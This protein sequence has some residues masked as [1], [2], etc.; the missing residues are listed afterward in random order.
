LDIQIITFAGLTI[1][2]PVTSLTDIVLA[3]ISFTFFARIK[4]RL[5]E[6]FFNNSW[7]MFFLFIGIST[8]IGAFAHALNGTD[9]IRWSAALF[10]AMTVFSSFAVFFALKATIRFT[11]LPLF[12]RKGLNT[13]NYS[14]LVIFMIYTLTTNN[15]EIFKMH[16][17]AGLLLI[18][19]THA[20]AWRRSHTGSGWIMAGM[21]ISF[22]TVLVHTKQFSISPWFNYKD[23][24]HVIMMVS[25]VMIYNGVYMMSENL[26][27]G[28][29]KENTRT[30]AI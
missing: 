24:S 25:L 18:F 4:N 26:K 7:R 21:G 12:A 23:I 27:R 1:G 6:S 30:K 5:N 2:E 17:A 14:L 20:I 11:N 10:M 22:F 28:V 29:F 16:A 13:T 3:V 19:I 8:S 9:A 15:F